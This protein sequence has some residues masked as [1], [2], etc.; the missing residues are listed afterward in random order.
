MSGRPALM[1]GQADNNRSA[2]AHMA[3]SDQPNIRIRF[4]V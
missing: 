1:M 4:N 2:K 3:D